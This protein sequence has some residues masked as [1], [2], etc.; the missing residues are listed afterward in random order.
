[1]HVE[2]EE[3]SSMTDAENNSTRKKSTQEHAVPD[4]VLQQNEF[5]VK[6]KRREE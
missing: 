6:L 1:M 3:G 5:V 2:I 4:N